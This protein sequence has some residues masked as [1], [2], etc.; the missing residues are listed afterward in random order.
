MNY[1]T[2]LKNDKMFLSL[3]SLHVSQV[4]Y[5]KEQLQHYVNENDE[6]KKIIAQIK[7]PWHKTILYSYNF[8]FQLQNSSLSDLFC[9]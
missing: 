7:K 4:A 9:I 5:L 6:L 8:D 3:T 1:E 2:V